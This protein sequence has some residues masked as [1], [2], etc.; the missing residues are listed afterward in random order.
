MKILIE[1]IVNNQCNRRC[2]YCDLNFK[3]Q[4]ITYQQLDD[5]THFIEKNKDSVE[6]FHLNFFW[7]EP[8]LSFDKIKYI[9]E[10][11]NKNF[12]R[13]SLWTNGDLLDDEK[14]KFFIL[15]KVEIYYSIDNIVGIRD[16][17][18]LK[19][20]SS[21]LKINFI[22]DP[23]YLDFSLSIYYQLNTYPFQ[24]IHFMPVLTSKRWKK[25]NLVD[26]LQIKKIVDVTTK[27]HIIYYWYTNNSTGEY[28]FVLDS[29]GYFYNDIDSLLW[30]QKQYKILPSSLKDEI[31]LISK[32]SY[33]SSWLDV[34]TLLAKYDYKKILYAILKIPYV[35]QTQN[36]NIL[37]DKILKDG[38]QKT[39]RI[40][41]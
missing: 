20:Y 13:Y 1:V 17:L 38:A 7:G 36:E 23:D 15:H 11:N 22:Q 12:V 30:I 34:K 16:K 10:K 26:L 25:Q 3:S 21:N 28:Q 19:K 31:E 37:L 2:E 33:L 18:F 9:I 14:M 6:Y 27:N 39:K 40:W 35:L 24:V 8:L 29:D 5:L 4:E 32:N 41:M